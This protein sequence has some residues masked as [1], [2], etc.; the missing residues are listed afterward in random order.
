MVKKK[1]EKESKISASMLKSFEKGIKEIEAESKEIEKL[2]KDIKY[3]S[4][5]VKESTETNLELQENIAQLMIHISR[6]AGNIEN[7]A[8]NI[9]IQKENEELIPL[10]DINYDNK[11]PEE[12][13]EEDDEKIEEKEKPE[14]EEKIDIA[15]QVLELSNQS[16]ELKDTLRTLGYQFKKEETR[17]K[18]KKALEKR[19]KWKRE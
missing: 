18:I 7:I 11:I 14:K 19:R 3:L 12:F 1:S 6:M 2:E 13:P 16:K 4:E 10:K 15:Q 8:E 5:K 9:G 17:E